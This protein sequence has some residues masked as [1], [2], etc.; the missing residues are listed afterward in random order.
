MM[1][2]ANYLILP[3]LKLILECCKGQATVED[4][5]KMKKDEL[6][7]NLYNSDYG[8]IVD[9]REFETNLDNMITK[10][11][12]N[13]FNF[14]KDLAV[15]SKIAFLTAEPHQVVISMILKGLRRDSYSLKIEVFSTIEAAVRYLGLSEDKLDQINNKLIELNNMSIGNQ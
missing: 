5:I 3:E 15:M 13:F 1:K 8:I 11:I 12:S 2:N 14:L 6:A 4:S 10:S 7:D 9:F